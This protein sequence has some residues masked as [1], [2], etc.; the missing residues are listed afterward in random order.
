M[1]VTLQVRNQVRDFESWKDAFDGYQRFREES[2]VRRHR[3]LRRVDDPS[4]VDVELDFD[5]VAEAGA[6]REKLEKVF[7]TPRSRQELLSH[8]TPVLLN[9]VETREPVG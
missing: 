1:T 2:G 4:R 5:S 3:V 7:A 9:L 6:F 8:E